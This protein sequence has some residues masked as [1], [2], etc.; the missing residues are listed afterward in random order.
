MARRLAASAMVTKNSR[1]AMGGTTEGSQS[2]LGWW[3]PFSTE[4][5]KSY[6]DE[7]YEI[8][9]EFAHRPDLI[10]DKFFGAASLAWLVLQYNSIVDTIEEL[11]AGQVIQIPDPDRVRLG[12][13]ALKASSAPNKL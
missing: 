10:A 6:A 1:Y 3:E 4:S 12:L 8:T 9:P 2:V 7:P 11:N 5:L 13:S